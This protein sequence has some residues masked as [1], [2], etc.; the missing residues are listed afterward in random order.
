MYCNCL[1][2]Q[3]PS[4]YI[5]LSSVLVCSQYDSQFFNVSEF[6]CFMNFSFYRICFFCNS[7]DIDAP[8]LPTDILPLRIAIHTYFRFTNKIFSLEFLKAIS[9]WLREISVK[10]CETFTS[11]LEMTTRRFGGV[12]ICSEEKVLLLF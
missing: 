5:S 10:F 1:V 2:C 9:I 11:Y 4:R 7:C 3:N 12:S 8:S 6:S